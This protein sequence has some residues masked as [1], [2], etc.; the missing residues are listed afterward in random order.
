[1]ELT[2]IK[3]LFREKEQY[4]EKQV[5]VGG[6]VR[7]NR[8]SKNFGFLVVNDGTF[9]EPL[10]IVYGS[11]MTNFGDITKIGVGAAVVVTGRIVETPGA[12]QPIEM[13][14]E[15]V[16]VEGASPADYPLQ[17]KRHSFEYLRTISHLRPRTNT[18]QAV[19]RVRSLAAFAI[20][21]F[22]QERNF[23]YVHTPLITGSDCE[24]AGEMFQVTTLDLENVPRTEEGKVDY[25][26]DF[27]CKPTNLTVSGQLDAETYAFAFR[28]VYT[29]GPTFRAENSNTTRHAAEFWMIEP[30][31]AFA[32]LK[33]DMIL[34]EGMLKYVI[35]YV[36]DN[37][38]EEM[39]FF[40][41]FVDKGLIE[42]LEHVL[43]SEFGHVTYTEAIEILEKHNEE[44]EYKVHWGSDLQTEHERY[45][46]E[47]EF[48]RPVFVTDYPKEIKAFYMKLNEDGKTVAA[49][50]CLVP[51]IGEI[52]GGSQREDKL[53]LLEKRMEE[54]NLNK[55]DYDFYLDLRRY[56]SA[57]HAGF[58]LGF[59]RCV[60][61]LTGMGNIRD[62][63]PFPRTVKN[64]EL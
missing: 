19:F 45:L 13:Q 63:I 11:E 17:K 35:R 22:F 56:G 34:A 27:F 53:E 30:E 25:S 60:M 3:D 62:V 23:V 32:D 18:F 44:F 16:L 64:C 50:D 49:M 4:K 12:K 8:D 33:D 36:L 61:Y 9:F 24:G 58:G 48:K 6:W 47:K 42:R 43:S 38:P 39:A 15:E 26:Q 7:S 28:N 1:M 37:A 31:M 54:M 2:N 5:T 20:H 46:T 51:G 52:I 57:R 41:Q 21:R 40:N 59:E 10:Q 14:A 55:E 29:F